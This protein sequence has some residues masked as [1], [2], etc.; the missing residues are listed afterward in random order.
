MM[1]KLTMI[2]IINISSPIGQ[3]ANPFKEEW[4]STKFKSFHLASI[5]LHQKGFK[6]DSIE[7][8]RTRKRVSNQ[9][10]KKQDK[11]YKSSD[12]SYQPVGRHKVRY[13]N[14]KDPP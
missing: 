7:W 9:S 5:Q 10:N 6:E 12:N 11:V 2:I 3:Y 4:K 1:R 13:A 8:L 14:K